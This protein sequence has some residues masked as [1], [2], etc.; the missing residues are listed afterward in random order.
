M[1]VN[2]LISNTTRGL[3]PSVSMIMSEESAL[4]E[5]SLVASG[6]TGSAGV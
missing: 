6:E 3:S 5:I 1:I 4:K 2:V